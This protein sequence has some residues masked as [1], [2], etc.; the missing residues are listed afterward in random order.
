MSETELRETFDHYDANHDG[1]I[2][3]SEF[4]ELCTALDADIADD[5]VDM[6]FQVIDTDGNGVIDF[7]EFA[8]WWGGR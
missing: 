7:N 4:G 6:G 2:Q 1:L 3:K 5:D 8:A